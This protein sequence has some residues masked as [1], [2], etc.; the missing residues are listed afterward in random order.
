METP[1]NITREE[2]LELAANKLADMYA[3]ES[4]LHDQASRIIRDRITDAWEREHSTKR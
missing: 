2:V 1:F 4:G 3:D